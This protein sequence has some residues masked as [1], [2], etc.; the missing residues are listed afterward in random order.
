M[1]PCTRTR[2]QQLHLPRILHQ[3]DSL[4]TV[5]IQQLVFTRTL[6]L[7]PPH[8]LLLHPASLC[9]PAATAPR[10]TRIPRQLQL[11]Q[12]GSRRTVPIQQLVFTKT[13]LLFPPHR[14]LLHPVSLSQRATTTPRST[15]TPHQLQLHQWSPMAARFRWQIQLASTATTLP[16]R[17][18]DLKGLQQLLSLTPRQLRLA[19]RPL[20]PA[21]LLQL[22]RMLELQ[23]PR[24][25]AHRL[26]LE[27]RQSHPTGLALRTVLQ[28]L[29]ARRRTQSK[30][31][32]HQL[33]H[34]RP[35]LGFLQ[36][37]APMYRLFPRMEVLLAPSYMVKLPQATLPSPHMGTFSQHRLQLYSL[38]AR[39]APAQ[40][41]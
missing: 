29:L 28:R 37:P 20:W 6:L 2:Q 17:P 22:H 36:V 3:L 13:L 32:F 26:H 21:L 34:R 41:R 30:F 31:S 5:P 19:I 14:Q 39:A 4:R 7:R 33:A 12:L 25:L 40:S 24:T 11:P 16:Q 9:H 38:Q 23:R 8:W 15:R 27:L 35:P 1:A 18:R 10:S